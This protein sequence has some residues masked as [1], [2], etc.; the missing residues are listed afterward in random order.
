MFMYFISIFISYFILYTYINYKWLKNKELDSTQKSKSQGYITEYDDFR[1]V[2]D[3]VYWQLD[4]I[5]K[6]YIKQNSNKKSKA[7]K[8][9]YSSVM[10]L[11]DINTS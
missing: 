10:N 4:E 2:Q 5:L 11:N 9:F 6:D 1:I 3:K 7:I 8:N